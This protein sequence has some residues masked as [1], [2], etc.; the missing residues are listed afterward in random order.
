MTAADN[1]YVDNAKLYEAFV[2]HKENV[3]KARKLGKPDPPLPDYIGMCFMLIAEKV[4][5][6]GSYSK[7]SYLDEMKDDAIENCIVAANNFDP[8][9]GKNPFAY[10]TQVTMWAF[11]RRIDKEKKQTYIKY[12][13]FRNLSVLG[14]LYSGDSDF[15][16][17]GNELGD[18]ADEIIA[19]YENSKREKEEKAKKRAKK[20]K[21]LENLFDE[22]NDSE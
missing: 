7:Y 18:V 9:K 14:E 21:G 16:S 20:K 3:T 15:V 1:H 22:E 2:K 6:K 10:F 19:N 11:H 13:Y 5:S 12:K 17:S 4:G 8:E